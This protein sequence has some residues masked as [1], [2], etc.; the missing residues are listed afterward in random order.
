MGSFLMLGHMA[1]TFTTLDIKYLS[2]LRGNVRR[3][4]TQQTW[5]GVVIAQVRTLSLTL[6]VMEGKVFP[7]ECSTDLDLFM[8]PVALLPSSVWSSR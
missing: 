7:P 5:P 8:D 4:P 2:I 6:V 1:R 3:Y